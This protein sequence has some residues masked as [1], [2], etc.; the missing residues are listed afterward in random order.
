MIT[1]VDAVSPIV[2]FDRITETRVSSS[3]LDAKFLTTLEPFV[4]VIT[5][6]VSTKGTSRGIGAVCVWAILWCIRVLGNLIVV[7]VMPTK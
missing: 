2:V 1:G 7:S 3:N 5:V 6:E 4:E